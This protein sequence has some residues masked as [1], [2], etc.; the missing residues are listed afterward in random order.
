ME[1]L[2]TITITLEDG[3]E[4]DFFVLEHTL[5]MG[6]SYYLVA[7]CG[8]GE[9]GEDECYILKESTEGTDEEFCELVFV[10]DEEEL[11]V[12]YPVFKELLEDSDMEVEF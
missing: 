6:A 7:P 5:L 11:E 10:D 8:V 2:E 12:L 3:K 4:V 1:K 9:D